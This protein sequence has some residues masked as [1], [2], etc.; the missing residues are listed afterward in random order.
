MASYTHSAFRRLCRRLGADRTYT[1]L[2][3]ARGIIERGIPTR[4]A[5]F[6]DEERPLHFQL[7]GSK[8]EELA[9]AAVIVA[10]QLRPDWIDLNLGCSVPK[11]LRN[12]AGA[13]LIKDPKRAGEVVRAMVEALKPYGIPVSV[14]TRL[15]FE[16]DRAEEIVYE[17]EK[18]GASLV[19]LHARLAVQGFRGKADWSRIA[20]VKR[21][22]TVPIIGNG[23]VKSF[24]DAERM[25]EET[26]CDA[27]MIGRA[28]LSNPWIFKEFKEKR[29]AYAGVK[30]RM[31]F[32]EQELEL[33][34]EYLPPERA[35]ALIK[36]QIVKILKGMPYAAAWK[37]YVVQAKNC[38]ELKKRI[39]EAAQGGKLLQV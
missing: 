26:G 16:K 29:P 13:Y 33:M 7:F 31:L 38:E 28:A 15:G 34:T 21:E 23:D 2:V 10:E 11:V 5:Y 8:P 3:S 12:E 22:A 4:Y 18:A 20:A 36:S 19:A 39:K 30:E 6:T 32:I 25:F 17:V 37:S 35:C 1:E 27:V 9:R 24:K 14:K